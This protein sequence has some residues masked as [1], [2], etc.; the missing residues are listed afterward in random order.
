MLINQRQH[1]TPFIGLK[2]LRRLA[3]KSLS[4]R[5]WLLVLTLCIVD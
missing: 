5:P 1:P 3:A 4:W 2:S